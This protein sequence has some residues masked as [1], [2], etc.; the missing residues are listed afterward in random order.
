MGFT[1]CKVLQHISLEHFS[2]IMPGDAPRHAN[3]SLTCYSPL[4]ENAFEWQL[5]QVFI[6]VVLMDVSLLDT[7]SR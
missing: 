5:M 1:L 3:I 4:S 6:L 2:L 7:L